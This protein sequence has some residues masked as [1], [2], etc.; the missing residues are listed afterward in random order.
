MIAL[1][2]L[3]TVSYDARNTG[4]ARRDFSTHLL[5]K[6]RVGAA[7]GSAMASEIVR[8]AFI[9]SGMKDPTVSAIPK[10]NIPKGIREDAPRVATA[11]NATAPSQKIIKADTSG[12]INI[13]TETRAPAPFGM[14]WPPIIGK[15]ELR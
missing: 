14:M 10:M 11:P 2:A 6:S 5:L 9:A 7:A 3:E 13:V 15:N 4:D 8:F 12:W 1:R